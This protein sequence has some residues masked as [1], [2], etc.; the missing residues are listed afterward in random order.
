M[1]EKIKAFLADRAY[2]LHEKKENRIK[3]MSIDDTLDE[4]LS[5]EKSLVRFGDGE[6]IMIRG[7]SLYF[8]D[9]SQE[10]SRRLAEILQYQDERLMVAIPDIFDGLSQYRESGQKF[11]KDHLL[12]FRSVYEKYCNAGR[13]YGNAFVS[14]CY[15]NFADKS[16]SE[17]WF[18]KI[19]SL[20]ADKNV[21]V[22]EGEG[23]HNGAGNDLL[24]GARGIKRILCPA[25]NAGDKLE[26]IKDACLRCPKDSLYLLS[27]GPAAK[28]LTQDLVRT[29]RRVIDIGNLDME[30]EWFLAGAQEKIKL[31]KHSIFGEEANRRA[32]YGAYWDEVI[33]RIV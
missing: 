24:S 14:R 26:Q 32:G 18:L 31:E 3:V 33:E 4:L 12:F 17:G 27:I 23:T 21:I 5:S 20:W 7:K 29:G 11:W 16:K 8:Q 9:S 28:L 13:G 2:A 30:Y 1:K 15:L 22:V 25:K 6:I 10:I 19:R